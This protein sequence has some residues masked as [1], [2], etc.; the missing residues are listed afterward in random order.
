MINMQYIRLPKDRVGVIIGK[1]G[2][3]KQELEERTGV[4]IDIDSTTGEVSIATEKAKD[5]I[6]AL[7][8]IDI[9]KAIG[10]GFSP[11]R[12]F[13]LFEEDVYLRGYDIR[14]YVGKNQKHVRR[15]RARLIGTKGKT[16]RVLEELTNTEI[17]IYG[18]TVYV[19]GSLEE[20]GI[21]ETAVDMLL[22]GSEHAA[23]YRFLEG[24]QRELKVSK[25]DS[26]ELQ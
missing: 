26:I 8:V 19:I 15:L 6:V 23:V 14:D 21:A 4:E 2:E 10:R 13:R 7:K 12:A 5:P 18:N 11:V 9:I 25:L 3:T 1:K 16:R 20:L 17:S 22:S 24:K